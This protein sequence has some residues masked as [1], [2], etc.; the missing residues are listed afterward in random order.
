MSNSPSR[1][2]TD[3]GEPTSRLK[4]VPTRREVMEFT[5]SEDELDNISHLNTEATIYSMVAVFV[6]GLAWD[7]L[8]DNYRAVQP[9]VDW[10]QVLLKDWAW[11]F[12]L[13]S[14]ICFAMALWKMI[15]GYSKVRRIKSAAQKIIFDE[16]QKPSN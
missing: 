14:L 2:W 7:V 15:G 11:F 8:R 13:L 6:A 5:V 16:D 12:V 9:S 3:T 4:S 10:D 1:P